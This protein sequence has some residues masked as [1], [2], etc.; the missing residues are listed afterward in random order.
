MRDNIT[1]KVLL[2]MNKK[3]ANILAVLFMKI[4]LIDDFFFV[5]TF[6]MSKFW[7]VGQLISRLFLNW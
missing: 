1:S 2:S 5:Q 4:L 3:N 6:S 7:F